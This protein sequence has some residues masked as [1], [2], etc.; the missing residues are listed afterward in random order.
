LVS[1]SYL[2]IAFLTLLKKK[3]AFGR[4][5]RITDSG[6]KLLDLSV[7]FLAE[8]KLSFFMYVH[9]LILKLSVGDSAKYFHQK[10]TDLEKELQML[11]H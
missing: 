7:V 3:R 9:I 8:I 2:V 6:P 4:V 1:K 10:Q 5:P 11:I